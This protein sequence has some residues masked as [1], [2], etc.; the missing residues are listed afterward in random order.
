MVGKKSWKKHGAWSMGQGATGKEGGS[1]GERV[2]GREGGKEQKGK[3]EG[4]GG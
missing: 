2:R 4:G 1:E 3:G